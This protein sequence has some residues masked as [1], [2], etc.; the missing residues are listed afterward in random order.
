MKLH[1]NQTQNTLAED[2]ALK[3]Q[4]LLHKKFS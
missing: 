1:K 3:V 2:G 4:V